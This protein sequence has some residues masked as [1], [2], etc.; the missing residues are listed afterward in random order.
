MRTHGVVHVHTSQTKAFFSYFNVEIRKQVEDVQQSRK[1][2]TT[3]YT[4]R[5]EK[6]KKKSML[7]N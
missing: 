1:Y 3:L 4:K 5:I 6:E 2:K 7:L